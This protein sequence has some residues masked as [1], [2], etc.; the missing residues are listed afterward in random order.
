MKELLTTLGFKYI[1]QNGLEVW[2]KIYPGFILFVLETPQHKQF[3]ASISIGKKEICIPNVIS[4]NWLN[5]FDKLN[6]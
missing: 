4:E 1:P 2:N 5:S 6:K 3:F